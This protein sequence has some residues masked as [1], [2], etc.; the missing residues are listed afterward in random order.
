MFPKPR[1]DLVAQHGR[2]RAPA[3]READRLSRV[4]RALAVPPGHQPDGPQRH[5]SGARHAG[6]QA[7]RAQALRGRPRLPLLLGP[8]EAGADDRPAGRR[9]RGARHRPRH[10]ADGLLRPVRARR[11]R[12]GDGHCQPQRQRLDRHQDGLQPAAHV[13]A[14]RDDRAEGDRA[15]RRRSRRRPAAATCSCPTSPSATSASLTERP[16]AEAQAQGGGG[17]RQ[18]HGGRLRAARAGGASAA[19]WCRSTAISTTPSRATI[20]I[21]KT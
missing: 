5:R 16:E 10:V 11:G 21:P 14:R 15:R 2:F 8:G 19:R 1:A 18:R 12:R 17:L 13:R 9:R 7:R 4:R 3:A 6:G 20:P